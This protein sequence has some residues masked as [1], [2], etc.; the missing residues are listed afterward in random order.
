MIREWV[1]FEQIVALASDAILVLDHQGVIRYANAAAERL[2]DRPIEAL[3][4]QVFG[5]VVIPDEPIEIEIPRAVGR[6]TSADMRCVDM[7]MDGQQMSVV[8]LRDVTER[9]Q[10]EQETLR[11]ETFYASIL[12]DLPEL[13]CRWLP[14]GTINYVNDNF[15]RY[16]GRTKEDLIGG[17]FLPQSPE[18]N[19]ERIDRELADHLRRLAESPDKENAFFVTEARAFR[20]DRVRRRQRWLNRGLFDSAGRI[21]EI[22]STGQDITEA[23]EA[24]RKLR[25]SERIVEAASSLAR[26]GGWEADLRNG[27]LTWSDEVCRLHEEPS[28]TSPRIE[29]GISYYAPEW[30][31][32]ITR[33]FGACARDGVGFDEALELITAGG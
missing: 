22:Q 17:R 1:Q 24:A 29:E 5:F 10:A 12:E 30:R 31:E 4:E 28:G 15:C 8:Y 18:T 25:E 21:T 3:L 9:K 6:I 33:T 19:R 7:A 32:R 11:R 26:I 20:A 14:D 27:Q 13:I 2:F 23:S 16:F